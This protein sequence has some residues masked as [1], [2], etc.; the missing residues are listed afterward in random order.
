MKD[1]LQVIADYLPTSDLSAAEG[2][3]VTGYFLVLKATKSPSQTYMKTRFYALIVAMGFLHRVGGR[4]DTVTTMQ[5]L[6]ALDAI[7]ES[8]ATYSQNYRRVVMH[9]FKQ[10][11]DGID[12]LIL[13]KAKIQKI[14]Q[15]SI[16]HGMILLYIWDT[17][18]K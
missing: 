8:K 1:I 3:L 2:E 10:V 6:L 15:K 17:K 11:L 7:R 5:A 12:S 14:K 18:P 16:S 9:I 4:L 13:D